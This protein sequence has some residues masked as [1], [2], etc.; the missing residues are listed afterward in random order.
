MTI[1]QEITNALKLSDERTMVELSKE[2]GRSLDIV[3]N[4]VDRMYWAGEL[5]RVRR[6]VYVLPEEE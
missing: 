3:Q 1:R 5:V 4:G 6:G 2:L